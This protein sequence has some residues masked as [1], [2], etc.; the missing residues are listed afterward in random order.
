MLKT[1]FK[2]LLSFLKNKRIIITTHNLV[3]IDGFVSSLT[4]KFF[5]NEYYKNQIV[6]IYLPELLKTTKIFINKFSQKFPKFNFKTKLHLDLSQFD[7]CLILDTNNLNLLKFENKINISPF[8][9]P[10]IFID[11]HYPTLKADNQNLN[12]LN[13]ILDYFSSTS[14]IIF[15][16]FKYYQQDIT[17]PYRYLFIAAIL[18]DSG[19]FNYGN[20][21]TINNVSDLLDEDLDFQE[22][23]SL[24]KEDINISEKIAKIKGL[25]RVKLIREGDYL[26]GISH[27]SSFG[28]SV[29][30]MLIACGVDISLVYSKTNTECKINA[31]AKKIVCLKTGIHLGKILK[32]ISDKCEGTGGGHD[33]A[34]SLSYNTEFDIILDKLIEKI[35]ESLLP[36]F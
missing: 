22:I 20:N 35:K 2:N 33:G 14:E 19:F 34:A 8:E 32:E 11:H 1:K 36:N 28:A 12:S 26:I 7:I 29:A 23:R 27:V 15:T 3:D 6:S 30:S 21:L 25:Q 18:A 10:Y 5:L 31:R 17:L 24:L 13:L 16:L 4:L 9:I